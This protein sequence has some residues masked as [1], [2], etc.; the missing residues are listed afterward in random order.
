M[1]AQPVMPAPDA[2]DPPAKKVGRPAA[3]RQLNVWMNGVQVGQWRFSPQGG[4]SFTYVESWLSDSLRRPLSLSIPLAGAGRVN[5]SPAVSAYFDNLLPD[6]EAIRTRVA[7]RYGAASANTFD[8]LAKIGRDCVGAVQILPED[9][10]APDVNVITSTPLTEAEIATLLRATV[11][12]PGIGAAIDADDF[13]VSIAGAQEKTALLRLDGAWHR[14][15][16]T[17]PT[18]H[19]FKLPLGIVGG[20]S[21]LDLSTSVENE[22]LCAQILKAY[23]LSVAD[24]EMATF[25]DQKVLIVERFDRR[26]MPDGWLAR[27]PQEDFCQVF[28]VNHTQKY[29]SDGGPG[30]DAILKQLRGSVEAK[31]DREAFLTAQLL[32]WMLAATDGHAK[33]FSIQLL[34]GDEKYRLTP[35]YDVLSAWPVIGNGAHQISYRKAKLAMAI[36]SKNRHYHL[37]EI[38]RRHWN[39]LAKRNAMGQDFEEVIQRVLGQTPKVIDQ[40]QATL[41]A[42]FPANVAEPILVGLREQAARLEAQPRA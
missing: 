37:D 38:Q 1:S 6:S 42:G 15:Q 2:D 29:E 26:W 4:Q 14:P 39:A 23:G 30:I 32:F 33:N 31:Q 16:G 21:K 12:P 20:D 34:P 19:I 28:G 25:G 18:T 10:P 35:L 17:T 41:P 5:T 24:C 22:W 27:I 9:S 11:I 40:V 3:T 8:L 36:R 13:R 7:G